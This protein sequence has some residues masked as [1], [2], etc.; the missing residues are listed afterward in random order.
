MND[1]QVVENLENGKISGWGGKREGSGRKPLLNKEDLAI[2]KELI[3]QHG[4]EIDP[5][6]SKERA[7][8]LMDKLYEHGKTGNI[9]AIKEYLDRQLGKSR[10]SI[11]HTSG[12]ERVIPVINILPPKSE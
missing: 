6:E 11:D 10:E 4:S 8:V 5:L 12:G 2:V 9:P 1:N 3:C 7:L